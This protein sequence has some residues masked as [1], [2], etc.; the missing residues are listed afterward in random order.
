MNFTFQTPLQSKATS[1]LI[2]PCD[3]SFEAF[4]KRLCQNHS[5]NAQKFEL[6]FFGFKNDHDYSDC[7]KYLQ[8]LLQILKQRHNLCKLTIIGSLSHF[9][10]PISDFLENHNDISFGYFFDSNDFN[11]QQLSITDL[12]MIT[13]LKKVSL[14]CLAPSKNETDGFKYLYLLDQLF[15]KFTI[16]NFSLYK[17]GKLPKRCHQFKILHNDP[18]NETILSLFSSKDFPLTIKLNLNSLSMPNDKTIEEVLQFYF[19]IICSHLHSNNFSIEHLSLKFSN[20]I[21]GNCSI[22][23]LKSL[24]K[25]I[26]INNNLKRVKTFCL[27]NIKQTELLV[28]FVTQH[29]SFCQF[30]FQ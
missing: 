20:Q 6:S 4:E 18:F 7:H 12:I 10:N 22:A 23:F 24:E 2:S 3:I 8:R 25:F 13:N 30:S 17:F 27:P 28:N 1:L 15:D 21:I 9:E 16:V 26:Q 5:I 19:E 14:Y 29:P 11:K